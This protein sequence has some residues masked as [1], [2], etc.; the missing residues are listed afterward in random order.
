MTPISYVVLAL[1][2]LGLIIAWPLASIALL[3]WLVVAGIAWLVRR[4]R[5]PVEMT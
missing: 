4:R 5:Q 3:I 1:G 2:L